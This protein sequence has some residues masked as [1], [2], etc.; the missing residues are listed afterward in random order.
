MAKPSQ[1][2]F[3]ERETTWQKQQIKLDGQREKEIVKRLQDMQDAIQTQ[4]DANWQNFAGSQGISI[5]EAY[6]QSKKMDVQAFARKAKKYVKEK[7]FSERAN[8]ELKVY[9]VTMRVNRL[10]L[11]KANIGLELI[12]GFNEVD[13]YMADQLSDGAIEEYR[14]QAG[15]LGI[16]VKDSDYKSLADSVIGGSFKAKDYPTFSDNLWSH[17]TDLKSDLD[18]LLMRGITLGRNSKT[19]A[20]DLSAYLTEQGKANTRYNLNRLMITEMGITQTLVQK[21]A[22]LEFGEDELYDVMPEPT[23]CDLCLEIAR[24]GPYPAKKMTPG[25]NAPCLHPFCHCSTAISLEEVIK[26]K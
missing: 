11:M 21:K 4:I 26:S 7:D 8:Q 18:K 19:L 12:N 24:K 13:R 10:E 9:N 25:V 20:G 15:I 6:K 2:Y 1:Q 17:Q 22:F 3:K 5:Q 16:D 14:R 23:A